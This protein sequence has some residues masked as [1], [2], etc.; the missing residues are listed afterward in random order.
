VNILYL[1]KSVLRYFCVLL[2]S[3]NRYEVR[4]YFHINDVIR[5]SRD[6]D[7][8][9]FSNILCTFI[10]DK[11]PETFTNLVLNSRRLWVGN[12]DSALCNILLSAYR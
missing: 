7:L 9:V 6:F 8:G 4:N 3:L 2:V 11:H 5:V 10:P 1:K 12:F